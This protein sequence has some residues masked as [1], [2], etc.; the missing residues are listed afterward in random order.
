MKRAESNLFF[1]LS[2]SV[3]AEKEIA[4]RHC[5]LDE[6]YFALIE[7]YLKAKETFRA[8]FMAQSCVRSE[9]AARRLV[10]LFDFENQRSLAIQFE[11][12]CD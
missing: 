3:L 1:R 8:I 2:A 5:E 4:Q 7:K 10:E 6:K 11:E 9:E 12:H